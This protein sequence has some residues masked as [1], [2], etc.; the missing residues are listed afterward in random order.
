MN[1]KNLFQS[2]G[3]TNVGLIGTGAFGQSFLDQARLI[4]GIKVSV[5]CDQD[6]GIA[7]DA[8]RHAGI[9]PEDL[10][11]CHTGS[12]ANDTI[13]SG[14][15]AVVS[16][17]LLLMDQPIEL[18]IEASGMPEAGAK[19]A[20]AAVENGKHVVMVTKE[21]DCVVGPALNR[22]AEKA[23]LVYT[24]ADGD[25]PSL[26][27]GLISWA[28]TL[29]FEIGCAGKAAE[30]D[31]VYEP[32]LKTITRGDQTAPLIKKDLLALAGGA[33][34]QGIS[35]R[36]RSLESLPQFS[37][38]D[39]CEMAI[40]INATGYDFDAPQLH[41]PIARIIEMPEIM[42]DRADGGILQKEGVIDMV[43]CLRRPDE[44][45]FAGGVFVIVK[46][47]GR[48]TWQLLKDK[49]HLVSRDGSRAMI[50]RPYHLLGVET[51]TSVLAA[52]R[53]K[54]STGGTDPEPRVD[55][56]VRASQTLQQ[57]YRLTLQPDH[58]IAG[59]VPEIL[60]AKKMASDSPIPYYMAAGHKLKHRVDRGRL[61]TYGMIDHDPKSCLWKLRQEQDELFGSRGH[62]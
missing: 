1:Y 61:L 37:V 12:D 3:V 58:S 9:A 44:I 47:R 30:L 21:T 19:H 55:V 16:D 62:K 13:A 6:I 4:P 59:V 33:A 38:A 5:V 50:F 22:L 53:L 60:S 51:A 45:S 39:L 26:L 15:T 18:V 14:K 43:N 23:G 32:G 11:I 28:E 46:C 40:V 24:P 49:G 20:L 41:A 2:T 35:R 29:G 27:I 31:F 42:C 57:G 36:R 56:G 10:K 8:C 25:Q 52:S 54:L 17:A 48:E 7:E 34:E